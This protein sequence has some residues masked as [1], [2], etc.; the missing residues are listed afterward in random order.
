MPTFCTTGRD[1]LSREIGTVIFL[2]CLWKTSKG[3]YGGSVK[4]YWYACARC[5]NHRQHHDVVTPRPLVHICAAVADADDNM[6]TIIS[7]AE[8]VDGDEQ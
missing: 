4:T 6:M 2:T 5:Q 3:Q 8:E 1:A 7:A